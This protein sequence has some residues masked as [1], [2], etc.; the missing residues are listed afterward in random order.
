M[1]KSDR[2]PGRQ[3]RQGLTDINVSELEEALHSALRRGRMDA[4][5]AL[6][7]ALARQGYR[8]DLFSG[9]GVTVVPLR[10]RTIA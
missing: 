6:V 2:I 9:V 4:V 10:P 5:R 8:A 3:S 1:A 7:G